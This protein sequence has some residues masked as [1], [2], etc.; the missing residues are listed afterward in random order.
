MLLTAKLQIKLQRQ[1][2]K[3]IS[4]AIV[5]ARLNQVSNNLCTAAHKGIACIMWKNH[6]RKFKLCDRNV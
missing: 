1:A 6:N 3:N 2:T 4:S 5:G